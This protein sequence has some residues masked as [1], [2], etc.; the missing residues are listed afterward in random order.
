MTRGL[1]ECRIEPSKSVRFTLITWPQHFHSHLIFV[2]P[3]KKNRNHFH[4][5]KNKLINAQFIISIC[6]A[7]LIPHPYDIRLRRTLYYV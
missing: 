5:F 6:S 2:D 1:E 4:N 3:Q 7:S